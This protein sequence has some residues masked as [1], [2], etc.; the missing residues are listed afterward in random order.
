MNIARLVSQ[1]LYG[2]KTLAEVAGYTTVQLQHV[3]FLKRDKWGNLV[4]PGE[5]LPDG[6]EVD[7]RGM[8]IP[9]KQSYRG[10]FTQTYRQI[11]KKQGLSDAEA[12]AAWEAYMAREPELARLV[13]QS[14]RMQAARRQR[15]R[16]PVGS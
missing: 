16:Q 5:E 11:K 2:G 9:S 1:L 3:L 7:E 14:Q 10:G 4:E 12:Q 15:S 8:R 13:A 6:V